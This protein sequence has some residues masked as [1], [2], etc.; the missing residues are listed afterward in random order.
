MLSVPPAPRGA[1]GLPIVFW[2]AL[3]YPPRLTASVSRAKLLQGHKI[4]PAALGLTL[5]KPPPVHP[6]GGD[7]LEQV[8]K[9]ILCE[10]R[11]H[12]PRESADQR[13]VIGLPPGHV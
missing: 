4:H 2:G 7:V 3:P 8:V 13:L 10:G 6:P 11:A 12:I 5:R 1:A 9:P